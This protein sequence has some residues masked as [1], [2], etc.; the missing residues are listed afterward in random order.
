MSIR[1][2]PQGTLA[3]WLMRAL[4]FAVFMVPTSAAAQ[5]TTTYVSGTDGTVDNGDTCGNPFVRNFTVSTNYTVSDVDIGVYVTHPNRGAMRMTLQSPAGTRVQIVNGNSAITGNNFN[6]RLNDGGTQ[7]VN[8]DGNNTNHS[9]SAPPPFQHNFTPNN[10]LSAFNGQASQGTWRLEICHSSSSSNGTFRHAELYLTSPPNADLSLNK[11]VS[12]PSPISG[13]GVTYTLTATNAAASALTATGVAV[14]DVLPAGVTYVS[15]SGAGTYNSGTGVWSVG[16]LAPNQSAVLTISVTVTATSGATI[17][18]SAEITAS[19]AYDQDSTPDN[20]VTGEDDYATVSFTVSGARVAG[21]PPTLMCPKSTI[22]FDWDSRAWT[23]AA[24]SA[25]YAVTGLGTMGFSLANPGA[26]L[27]LFGGM[28]PVRTNQ[29]T[30]G[31]TPAQYGI[32]ETVNLANRNQVV[33]TTITLPLAVDGAQFSIFDVDFGSSQFADRVRV[34]GTFNGA[35]VTPV[36]TNGVANY[37]IGNEAFGD[38]AAGNTSADG[39][40]VVTFQSAVDTIVIEYGNHSLAPA[41]PGQQAIVLH[42]ILLCE[43]NAIISVTKIS[44]LLSD[45]V[46]GSTNPLAIPGALVSYCILVGNAGSAEATAVTATDAIPATMTYQAGTLRSGSSCAAATTGEDD[47]ATGADESDP[48]GASVSGNLLQLV[49]GTLVSS[50]TLAF[51]FNAVV[52]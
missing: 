46:R 36:L 41:D 4:L 23:T 42:D 34:T 27:N 15:H 29:V 16:S 37:V 8:T 45:P 2:K 31:L 38:V 14:T 30:G 3:A 40:V 50:Q 1:L 12:N 49:A 20:G 52:N 51:T 19:S 17:V 25:S 18:N 10:L 7:V 32:A 5:T 47:D 6:V 13:A 26:W 43:P 39:N 9:T 24:T 22:L 11:A 48:V 21:T 35:P 28:N 44:S 33:T